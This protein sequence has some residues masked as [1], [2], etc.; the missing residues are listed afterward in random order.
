MFFIKLQ[1]MTKVVFLI[2][3]VNYVLRSVSPR[4]NS[5]LHRANSTGESTGCD[6][7]GGVDIL[8]TMFPRLVQP[9]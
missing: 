2:Y 5:P 3:S 1:Y 6:R 7:N 4:W 8:V 9:F